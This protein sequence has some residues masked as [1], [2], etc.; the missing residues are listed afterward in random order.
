MRVGKIARARKKLAYNIDAYEAK[1]LTK[2][3]DPRAA[4]QRMM[5]VK[6]R[7]ERAVLRRKIAYLL[8]V[9]DG[10]LD[11]KAMAH[12]ARVLHETTDVLSGE[13]CDA[14][15]GKISVSLFERRAFLDNRQPRKPRLVDF[16]KQI[17]EQTI[18]ALDRKS[19]LEV[20]V[21]LQQGVRARGKAVGGHLLENPFKKFLPINLADKPCHLVC[22]IIATNKVVSR[23]A[24]AETTRALRHSILALRS[25]SS[26]SFALLG[27]KPRARN[28]R[29][30]NHSSHHTKA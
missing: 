14:R 7:L 19:V 26:A 22:A 21:L 24:A 6:P 28:G 27:A 16:Q 29:T 15:D 20:V 4:L 18:V 5:L 11:F 1:G 12:D 23:V 25:P 2:K 17:L 13:S 3:P 8:C 9:E 30:R 10:S